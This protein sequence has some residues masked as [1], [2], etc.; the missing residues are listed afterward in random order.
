VRHNPYFIEPVSR[1]IEV[2]ENVL[3]FSILGQRMRENDPHALRASESI[4]FL[5]ITATVGAMT[6]A[7]EVFTWLIPE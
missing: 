2:A 7:D 4:Q 6:P 3:A 1:R 5:Q